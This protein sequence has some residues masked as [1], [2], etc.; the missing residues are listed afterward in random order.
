MKLGKGRVPGFESPSLRFPKILY[1]QKDVK[2]KSKFVIQACYLIAIFCLI[3]CGGNYYA[4]DKFEKPDSILLDFSLNKMEV[5]HE[6][7]ADNIPKT[8]DTLINEVNW[9]KYRESKKFQKA[10]SI[11]F[12]KMY[13]YHVT[14]LFTT[15]NILPTNSTSQILI[16][17][18]SSLVGEKNSKQINSAKVLDYIDSNNELK[19]DSDIKSIIQK[20]SI[21][22]D[23]EY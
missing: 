21:E 14:S 2:M 10:I 5:S 17:E 22:V 12:L 1:H 11:I 9:E 16:K 4:K 13:Q 19:K 18:F 8:I 3:K 7:L 6:Q 23:R 20:V 15:K